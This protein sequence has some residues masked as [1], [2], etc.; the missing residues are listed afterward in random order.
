[1]IEGN[2][3]DLTSPAWED[4]I[5]VCDVVMDVTVSDNFLLIGDLWN[6]VEIFS[7]GSDGRAEQVGSYNSWVWVEDTAVYGSKL[8]VKDFRGRLEVVDLRI[9]SSPRRE[10]VLMSGG[11]REVSMRMGH[12]IA[13]LPAKRQIK[14]YDVEVSEQ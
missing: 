1:V 10:K 4:T 3:E 14:A 2:I 5:C 7:I 13:V 11:A 9:P 6:G 12:D 8:Y